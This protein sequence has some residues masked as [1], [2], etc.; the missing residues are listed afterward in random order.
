M[1]FISICYF[2]SYIV[3]FIISQ[4]QPQ[5]PKYFTFINIDNNDYLISQS[6]IETIKKNPFSNFKLNKEPIS[7]Q[8]GVPIEMKMDENLHPNITFTSSYLNTNDIKISHDGNELIKGIDVEFKFNVDSSIRPLDR[9]KEFNNRPL[10]TNTKNT[11]N[12]KSTQRNNRDLDICELNGGGIKF[13]RSTYSNQ[14]FYDIVSFSKIAFSLNFGEKG[15]NVKFMTDSTIKYIDMDD[16]ISK[17]KEKNPLAPSLIQKTSDLKF[18]DLMISNQISITG[19]HLYAFTDSN[20]L[21]IYNITQ[22]INNGS[23]DYFLTF[24]NKIDNFPYEH[25]FVDKLGF[26]NDL[27]I[28]GLKTQESGLAIYKLEV[29]I[30]SE[31]NSESSSTTDNNMNNSMDSMGISGGRRQL[32]YISWNIFENDVEKNIELSQAKSHLVGT[33]LNYILVSKFNFEYTGMI[34]NEVTIYILI[35]S[36][37]MKLIDLRNNDIVATKDTLIYH[38]RLTQIQ[39][40]EF[41]KF[42]KESYYIGLSGI[43]DIDQPEFFFEIIANNEFKPTYNRVWYSGKKRSFDNFVDNLNSYSVMYD[44]INFELIFLLRGVPD[45]IDIPTFAISVQKTDKITLTSGENR[46]HVVLDSNDKDATYLIQDTDD[47]ISYTNIEMA[48]FNIVC[49]VRKIGQYDIQLS[50]IDKC[51]GE[52]T[53][54]K[55]NLTSTYLYPNAN[56]KGLIILAIIIILVLF[57]VVFILILAKYGIICK[58]KK[59]TAIKNNTYTKPTSNN[60]HD[61][62]EDHNEIEIN[63]QHQEFKDEKF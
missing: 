33:K 10:D 7:T 35:K 27:L 59:G 24:Y 28:V 31:N 54:C 60:V 55:K 13:T 21:L 23:E 32:N 15:I 16:Y 44:K 41:S 34:I 4:P 56:R 46:V 53:Y 18:I 42:D 37:G 58:S 57:L 63:I 62:K 40:L 26:Y 52:N 30:M 47:W 36:I 5:T 51:E 20:D 12:T 19:G 1:K 3:K 25:T 39:Y 14:N 43:S 22:S 8:V 61:T 9:F 48:P 38:K 11:L 17:L 50:Y 29:E 2:F 6:T 49:N 45:L